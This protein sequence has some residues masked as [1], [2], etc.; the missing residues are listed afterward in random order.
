VSTETHVHT[1]HFTV[2]KTEVSTNHEEL[3][4]VQIKALVPG[5]DPDDLL[6]LRKEGQK[7]P[8]ADNKRVEIE[9]GMHFVTYP[10]GRDS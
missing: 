7:I 1:Y 9:N 5:L 10:G 6:E 4:G 8:I 2:N 3:T